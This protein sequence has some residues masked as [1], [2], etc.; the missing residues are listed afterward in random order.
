MADIAAG[1]CWRIG[2]LEL[3][4]RPGFVGG[5]ELTK[6]LGIAGKSW[7]IQGAAGQFKWSRKYRLALFA[8][9]SGKLRLGLEWMNAAGGAQIGCSRLSRYC[10][11]LC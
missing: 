7:V 10:G 2:R 9:R 6:W 3:K 11:R 8:G 4:V 5:A 1:F